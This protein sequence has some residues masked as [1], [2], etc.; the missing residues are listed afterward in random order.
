MIYV[1]SSF[2]G[3]DL[4]LVKLYFDTVRTLTNTLKF[5]NI[6]CQLSNNIEKQLVINK[7]EWETFFF[8]QAG[9]QLQLE[10]ISMVAEVATWNT[11]HNPVQVSHS[12]TILAFKTYLGAHYKVIINK[13]TNGTVG[14]SVALSNVMA[15]WL[16]SYKV[17]HLLEI[18]RV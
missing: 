16:S 9:T 6:L 18:T 2:C 14:R 11:R 17:V 13:S 4:V 10:G 1:H 15:S 8:R 7:W 5:H 3:F 12:C